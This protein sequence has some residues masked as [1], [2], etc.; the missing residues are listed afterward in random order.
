REHA[1]ER[2]RGGGPEPGARAVRAGDA[3]A[4][5][6]LP[7][8]GAGRGDEGGVGEQESGE[9]DES[10]PRGEAEGGEEGEIDEE[11]RGA[12]EDAGAERATA[13]P[14]RRERLTALE[15]FEVGEGRAGA[16]VAA[17]AARPRAAEDLVE[18]RIEAGHD[19]A[20]RLGAR[21]EL[22]R[23]HLEEEDA[24]AVE[25][26]ARVDGLARL[27]LLRGEVEGARRRAA[28]ERDRAVRSEEDALRPA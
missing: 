25:V 4:E 9:R 1:R 21:G 11:R 24:P 6:P 22:A 3:E 17:R 27:P 15:P 10:A 7:G 8:R 2:P 26:G 28:P 14:A 18:P 13:R 5:E 23:Q 20:R 12:H 16:P 19:L